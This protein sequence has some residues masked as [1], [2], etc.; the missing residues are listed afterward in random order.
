QTGAGT[1]SDAGAAL[2]ISGTVLHMLNHSMLKLLLFMAAGVVLMNVHALS[3]DD[4]RGWGRNKT[5]LKVAFAV[6]GLGIS[7]VPLL[8]GYLSKSMLHEGI[9]H[10]IE[11]SEETG[12]FAGL[13]LRYFH[14][15]EW[16][17]LFSGGL[18]FA[19][20][21]KLFLCVFVERNTDPE[22]QALYNRNPDCMDALSTAVITLSALLLVVLGQPWITTSVARFAVA[23]F[24]VTESAPHFAAFAWENLHGGLISLSIGAVVYVVVVRPFLRV[25]RWPRALNLEARLYTPLFTKWLP[26]VFGNVARLFAD[27]LVLRRVCRGVVF[28]ASVLSQAMNDSTDALLVLLRRSVFREV[29]LRDEQSAIHI[30]RLRA[31]RRATATALDSF[32]FSFALL[33]TCLGVILILGLLLILL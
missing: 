5:A 11:S 23:S 14:A 28:A 24:G 3:L 10:L 16:V 27:N 18:T 6:G 30:G 7:G 2:A 4:I 9:V 19:Y 12:F 17:F 31:L 13:T 32:N 15:A 29:K 20:M 8:N 1:L 21:L 33:M 26:G 25:D 22:R